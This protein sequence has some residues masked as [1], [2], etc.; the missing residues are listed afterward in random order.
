MLRMVFS[1]VGR[2]GVLGALVVK[3]CF[4]NRRALIDKKP[5]SN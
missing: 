4:R 5:S 2:E 1:D 3:H